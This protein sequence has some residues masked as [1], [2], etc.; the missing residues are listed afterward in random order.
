M[1]DFTPPDDPGRAIL[2]PG[3]N[4]PVDP[5]GNYDFD[6]ATNQ[7]V[8]KFPVPEPPPAHAAPG[9]RYEEPDVAEPK[10]TVRNL[11]LA[12][13]GII[14]VLFAIGAF[15]GSGSDGAAPATTPAATVEPT[16]EPTEPSEPAPSPTEEDPGDVAPDLDVLA[17]YA[18]LSDRIARTSGDIA[19]AANDVDVAA[20]IAAC[21]DLATE[22]VEGTALDDT[23]IPGV[24]ASWDKAM[25]HYLKAGAAC[26]A[27]DFDT[28][29]TH[30]T[31]G[32]AAI[33]DAT[34]A[35]NEYAS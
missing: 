32:T 11:I 13:V 34:A 27:G 22:A 15:A 14:V 7:W 8:P 30:I 21:D 9:H 23:N 17:D 2:P 12:G 20:V 6:P 35:V 19:D 16:P 5:S 25:T 3:S 33:Q 24:D 1:S 31:K 29:T 4:I 10:H 18:D 28:A 26:M